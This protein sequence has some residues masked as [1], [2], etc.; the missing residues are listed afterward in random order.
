MVR[1]QH[2]S[3]HLTPSVSHKQSNVRWVEVYKFTQYPEKEQLRRVCAH[4]KVAALDTG[5]VPNDEICQ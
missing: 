2:S 5:C 4:H 1:T 3:A